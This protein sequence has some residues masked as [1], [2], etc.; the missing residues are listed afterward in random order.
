MSKEDCQKWWCE[1]AT[2]DV[3]IDLMERFPITIIMSDLNEKNEIIVKVGTSD[4]LPIKEFPSDVL[5]K[6][7]IFI[8]MG[9]AMLL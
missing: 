9:N 8:Q 5:G 7:V 6:Q 2:Q 4:G 3:T 1:R